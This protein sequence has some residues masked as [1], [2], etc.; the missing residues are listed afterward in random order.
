MGYSAA[1]MK[2]IRENAQIICETYDIDAFKR[3]LQK[4]N[5]ASMI[6]ELDV[7]EKKG[8]VVPRVTKNN[9]VL[10]DIGHF[11]LLLR[12]QNASHIRYDVGTAGTYDLEDVLLRRTKIAD[13]I[14]E[15]VVE[16]T[17]Y[18]HAFFSWIWSDGSA[19]FDIRT[20]I[21]IK[22][23]AKLLLDEIDPNGF[24]AS[25]HSQ[26]TNSPVNLIVR[27]MMSFMA[28]LDTLIQNLNISDADGSILDKFA[29]REAIIALYRQWLE[30]LRSPYLASPTCDM[31]FDERIEFFNKRND[32]LVSNDFEALINHYESNSNLF[33]SEIDRHAEYCLAKGHIYGDL[34][35]DNVKAA[36]AFEEA[37]EYDPSNT[38]AFD[39]VSRHLREASQWDQLVE[40]FSNHWDAVNSVQKRCDMLRECAAIQAFHCQNIPEA[41]GLYER[42]MLEGNPGNCFDDIYKIVYGL[43]ENSTNME[44]LRVLVT[45]TM[46]ITNYAQRDKVVSLQ[47]AYND[48]DEPA[49][50][51]LNS[52]INAG[53]YSFS[54]D[55]PEALQHVR[56]AFLANPSNSLIEGILY[57]IVSKIGSMKE[58]DEVMDD[59]ESES[60]SARDLSLVL[61]RIA[62]VLK[63]FPD[64]LSNALAYAEHAVDVDA[65]NDEAV[66]I[67][68]DLSTQLS[69]PAKRF[70]YA[71]LKLARSKNEAERNELDGIC[72]ELKL[73]FNDQDDVLIDVYE[74]CLQFE[75]LRNNI[76]D[77]LK[78]LMS[79]ISDEKA[80]AFIQRV[81]SL[82]VSNGLTHLMGEL[83][84]SVLERPIAA[85]IRKSLLERYLGML[86]GQTD[87]SSRDTFLR[88]HAQ[89]F[90]ISPSPYLATLLEKFTAKNEALLRKWTSYIE[91]AI[92]ETT[93]SATQI[94]LYATL[95]HIYLD[96]LKDDESAAESAKHILNID[97]ASVVAFKTCFGCHERRE[98]YFEC[99]ELFRAFPTDKFPSEDRK[100]YAQK[101]LRIALINL[102][103]TEKML[104]SIR[105]LIANHPEIVLPLMDQMFRWQEKS[106]LSRDQLICFFEMFEKQTDDYL[107]AV[108]HAIRAELLIKENRADEGLALLDAAFRDQALQVDATL[109]LTARVKALLSALPAN[110]SN[111]AVV[112]LWTSDAAGSKPKSAEIKAIDRSKLPKIGD[113][114]KSGD[115]RVLDDAALKEKLISG[116]HKII[117]GDHKAISGDH[118]AISGDNKAISGDQA[119]VKPAAEK[120]VS[121]ADAA[122]FAKIDA[123]VSAC[124]E[125]IDD[126]AAIAN[127][128]AAI[129]S[130]EPKF[131]TALA[132]KIAALFEELNRKDNA[133][134]YYKSAFSFTQSYELLEFY[135]RNRKFKKAL[136]IAQ[137]KEKQMS[138]PVDKAAVSIDLALIY[139]QIGDFK[140]A[141]TYLD[142][143][144]NN[145]SSVYGKTELV[146]IQRQKAALSIAMHD[147]DAAIAILNQ[148]ASDIA[149][150]DPKL[151]EEIDIDL[152][153][154]LRD[155]G[156]ADEARKK[157]QQLMLRNVKNARMQLFA[158]CSD[159]DAGKL[160]EA[161]KKYKVLLNEVTGTP[162][163]V[164]ALEQYLRICDKRGDTDA[165]KAVAKQILALD[166][167]NEIALQA[168]Q[169]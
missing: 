6:S 28:D 169:A 5:M 36:E 107:K 96:I 75:V 79:T 141:S 45:L 48:S 9:K 38:E 82:C 16:D 21:H 89:L 47:N 90:C 105:V 126:P 146:N 167:V 84:E 85:N 132:V 72:E 7:Y 164:P 69:I 57:R 4:R 135:K 15:H 94:K 127:V 162:M 139:Q 117:S 33:E 154:L 119:A 158:L 86:N 80:V 10:Y 64:K 8:L 65:T 151:K 103:D 113:K 104:F 93:D 137:F 123:L 144:L 78:S 122:T 163:E 35:Q 77:D 25:L 60:I 153:F 138:D 49:S 32:I 115:N 88:I 99:C 168:D 63:R 143:V 160:V 43:M 110:D 161:E 128:D 41:I 54:G 61:T 102:Y 121:E 129:A 124:R 1:Q 24:I 18:F 62:K 92:S 74:T 130:F 46:H 98:D 68:Y 20:V 70:V 136:K 40:L 106:D 37:L 120:S 71:S 166:P 19:D 159:V 131:K 148:A 91:E 73:S 50:Q 147:T 51:C 27:D 114:L 150:Q 53:N 108:F 155:A 23:V 140:N 145:Y 118:K 3:L 112:A 44:R 31:M 14:S 59:I 125:N 58:F 30:P 26:A 22:N 165:K 157:W 100:Y 42:C 142:N 52:L 83:Y 76:A 13:L 12:I 149:K 81:E 111:K 116:D 11:I 66:S 56:K 87:D 55:Q 156:Q 95:T 134:K 34:L 67:A 29:D 17:K 133:E 101:T 2:S 39:L 97:P 152:C 109:P